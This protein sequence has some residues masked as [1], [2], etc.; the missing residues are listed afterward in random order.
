VIPGDR[1]AAGLTDALA[2]F[3]RS[4]ERLRPPAGED[5]NDALRAD[6]AGL[7][8]ALEARGLVVA[9]VSELVAVAGA[10]GG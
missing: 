1:A 9:S 5:G 2:S 8:D 3:A 7:C 4:I 10:G 6:Y